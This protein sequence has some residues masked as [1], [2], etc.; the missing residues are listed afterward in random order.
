MKLKLRKRLDRYAMGRR[1]AELELMRRFGG[2]VADYTRAVSRANA[3]E[4]LENA[5]LVRPAMARRFREAV[6]VYSAAVQP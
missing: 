3:V 1:L 6:A 2:A 4:S 5:L